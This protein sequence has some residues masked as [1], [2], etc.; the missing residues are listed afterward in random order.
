MDGT[1]DCIATDHAPHTIEEK[2]MDFIHTPCGMIG[3][4]SAFGLAHTVLVE[5]GATTE[6]VIQWMTKGSAHVMGW[7]LS[8]F[9]IGSPAEISIIDPNEEWEFTESHIKSRSKNSPM[10]GMTFKGRV[11]TTISGKYALGKHLD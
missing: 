6:Q 7:E 11:V 10:V 2:E 1:I 9:D 5:A 3:L 4:E 8:P